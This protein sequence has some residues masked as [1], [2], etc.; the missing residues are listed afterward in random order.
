M[1]AP[2]DP[3]AIQFSRYCRAILLQPSKS[4]DGR[5]VCVK[6]RNLYISE[7]LLPAFFLTLLSNQ[8]LTVFFERSCK[9]GLT[10]FGAQDEMVHN[11]M[12]AVLIS[13]VF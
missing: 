13:P 2:I 11:Q 1:A 9:N 5:N 8:L 6:N 7:N 12:D 10:S 3:Y 4:G